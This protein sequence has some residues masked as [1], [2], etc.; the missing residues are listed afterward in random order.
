MEVE[1]AVP[2][3]EWVIGNIQHAGYY[4]VNY[5]DQNWKLLINQLNKDHTVIGVVN[6]AALIDDAFNL[7]KAEWI[8]QLVFFDMIKYLKKESDPMPF[9]TAFSGL[10]SVANLITNYYEVNALFEVSRKKTNIT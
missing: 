1:L 4:R 2:S 9:I 10:S 5:D 8:D 3:T 7:G 6:R